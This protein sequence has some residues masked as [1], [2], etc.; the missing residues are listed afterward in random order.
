MHRILTSKFLTTNLSN[1]K[2]SLSETRSLYM[3]LADLIFDQS[4]NH[5]DKRNKEIYLHINKNLIFLKDLLMTCD[6]YPSIQEAKADGSL[7]NRGQAYILYSK[8][9]RVTK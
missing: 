3:A 4:K 9:T 7:R 2:I 6:L 5:R 1:G 8:T